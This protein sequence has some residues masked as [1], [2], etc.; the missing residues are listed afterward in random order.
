MLI[1]FPTKFNSSQRLSEDD[2]IEIIEYGIPQSW[3]AKMVEQSF[4]PVQHMLAEIIEFCEKMEYAEEMI[5][6]P[7]SNKNNSYQGKTGQNAEADPSGGDSNTGSLKNAKPSQGSV[8]RRRE[9]HQSYAE[10]NGGDG[11]CLHANATDHMTGECRVLLAQAK[12]MRAVWDAQ[13]RENLVKRQKTNN[14]NSKQGNGNQRTY[15]KTSNGDFHTLL[16][17]AERIKDSLERAIRQQ[18]TSSGKR[19]TRE[20]EDERNDEDFSEHQD[21]D[22]F[23]FELDQ[24]SLSDNEHMMSHDLSDDQSHE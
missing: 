21:S 9:R 5:S 23:V 18:E 24:Q 2:F 12:R 6:T 3:R 22:N 13:P 14:N 4:I 16:N 11:C 19:K 7:N 1:E 8:K 15:K 17:Q 10:S 20:F